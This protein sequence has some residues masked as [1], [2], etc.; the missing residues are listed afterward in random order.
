MHRKITRERRLNHFRRFI[1]IGFVIGSEAVSAGA[2]GQPPK[3]DCDHLNTPHPHTFKAGGFFR[4][5]N[6]KARMF[7]FSEA[8]QEYEQALEQWVHPRIYF[9]M[10]RVQAA[11]NQPIEAYQS[12]LKATACGAEPLGD[13][14]SEAKTNFSL[15]LN[16]KRT[17]SQKVSKIM[18]I[19]TEPGINIET[20]GQR[21]EDL[22][23]RRTEFVLPNTYKIRVEKAGHTSHSES[24]TTFPG[25]TTMLNVTS[26]YRIHPWVPWFII[27]MGLA[28][29]SV[30]GGL[31]G[32][33]RNNHHEFIDRTETTCGLEGCLDPRLERQWS[34]IRERAHIGLG[35]IAAGGV[36]LLT[37]LFLVFW[38][39]RPALRT[40]ALSTDHANLQSSLSF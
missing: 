19:P 10:S 14:S 38:N 24:I 39:H 20:N 16:L 15:A 37:G 1:V 34:G 26:E 22:Q 12:I 32:L 17:L 40:T 28:I 27:G 4:L 7:L 35:G 31:Y 30:G 33:A 13:Q 11:M 18:W 29:G 5:G 8:L 2:F 36:T 3:I 25:Q 6:E 23:T 9:N 21:I